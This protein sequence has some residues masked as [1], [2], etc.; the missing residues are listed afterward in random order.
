[1]LEVV[2]GIIKR[3]IL[4]VIGGCGCLRYGEGEK[5]RDEGGR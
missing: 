3:L 1:M 4:G 5:G 2:F